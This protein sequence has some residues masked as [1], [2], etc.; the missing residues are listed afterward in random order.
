M[1]SAKI[2]RHAAPLRLQVVRMLREDIL[3]GVLA[4]GDR[5]LENALCDSYG[6]SRT[7]VREALRQLETESLIT[8]LPGRG[9]IVTVLEKHDIQALYQ[10]RAALEGLAA[11][12][13]ARDASV[14]QAARMRALIESMESRYLHGTVETREESKEE[15]Y[16][17]LLEGAGNAV[18]ESQLRGVHTRIGLFR[19]YAFVD[20]HRVAI[21]MEELRQIVRELAVTRDPAAARRASEHHIQLAGELA[22]LEY[23]K[24]LQHTEEV[25]EIAI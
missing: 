12:L 14:E 5:L 19:R 25:S 16:S 24:R 20:E 23:T 11:E 1:P 10:V 2:E 8:M 21:S 15:F 22:V 18:L 4:P 17:L 6:V 9:P 3:E 7:V 13:F